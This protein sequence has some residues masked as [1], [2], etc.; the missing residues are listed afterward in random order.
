MQE[1]CLAVS[2][3]LFVYHFSIFANTV[4]THSAMETQ[5]KWAEKKKYPSTD[6]DNFVH[7]IPKQ[8]F[9]LG[10][11]LSQMSPELLS[12]LRP[13]HIIYKQTKTVISSSSPSS[14]GWRLYRN[15]VQNQRILGW[16]LGTCTPSRPGKWS[17][18]FFW[19]RLKKNEHEGEEFWVYLEKR[20]EYLKAIILKQK[21]CKGLMLQQIWRKPCLCFSVSVIYF[22][23]AF[24]KEA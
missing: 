7:W 5:E 8:I 1:T 19:H 12:L 16:G 13:K 11:L 21:N 2:K 18:P 23:E 6:S 24:E 15:T 20:E 4:S 17:C 10:Q 22:C 3:I 9:F 14:C